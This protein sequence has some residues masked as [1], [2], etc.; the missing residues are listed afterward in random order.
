MSVTNFGIGRRIKRLDSRAV[1]ALLSTE[2]THNVLLTGAPLLR[3]QLGY[4]LE[5]NIA[6]SSQEFSLNKLRSRN[7]FDDFH[8]LI[9]GMNDFAIV[10]IRYRFAKHNSQ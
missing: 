7:D 9:V 10:A 5:A 3:V 4:G 1:T 8:Y 2:D 6:R